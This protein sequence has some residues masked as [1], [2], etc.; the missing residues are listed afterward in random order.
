M[1]I[2]FAKLDANNK[3]VHVHT[4]PQ[5]KAASEAK[6]QEYLRKLYWDPTGVYKQTDTSMSAGV[7]KDGGTPYRKNFAAKGHTY[8]EDRDAFLHA[9]PF[10]SWILNEDTCHYD[11]PIPYPDEERL[12]LWNEAEQKWDLT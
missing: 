8:D 4:I 7:H 12:A 9:Q 6:G 10:P 2:A 5:D 3:V 1:A 11:P